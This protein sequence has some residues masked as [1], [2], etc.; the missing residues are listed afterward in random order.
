MAAICHFH[1]YCRAIPI[2]FR[3]PY[4]SS[5]HI[6]TIAQMQRLARCCVLYMNVGRQIRLQEQ[7]SGLGKSNGM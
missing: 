1:F 5:L 4:I 7:V 3:S 2:Y 6:T